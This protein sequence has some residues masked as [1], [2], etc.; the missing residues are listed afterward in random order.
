M[1]Q[2]AKLSRNMNTA[3]G[4]QISSKIGFI[5]DGNMAKAI[6]KSIAKHGTYYLHLCSPVAQ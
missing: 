2:I 1:N 5:G 3:G 6:Y 4:S